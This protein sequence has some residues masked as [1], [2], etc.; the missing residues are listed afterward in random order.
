L[1]TESGVEYEALREDL[2]SFK[3]TGG[4][5]KFVLDTLV[6]LDVIAERPSTLSGPE[7]E[8]GTVGG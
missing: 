7:T 4:L 6:D 1:Y 8:K 2:K 3:N 5:W